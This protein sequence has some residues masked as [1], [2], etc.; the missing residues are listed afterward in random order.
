M[1]SI[2]DDDGPTH[3]RADN[4]ARVAEALQQLSGRR[5]K[6]SSGNNFSLLRNVQMSVQ[7]EQGEKKLFVSCFVALLSWE[8]ADSPTQRRS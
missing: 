6:Q 7:T 1:K 4:R 8:M 5:H 3:V 2:V